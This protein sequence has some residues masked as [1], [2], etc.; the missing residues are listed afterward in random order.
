MKAVEI[1]SGSILELGA[2]FFSTP[3]LHWACFSDK[4]ELITYEHS[5]EYYNLFKEFNDTF[6]KVIK[7]DN[8][9]EAEIERSWD[10][11]LVDHD[12]NRRAKEIS[13][14]ANYVQYIVVHDSDKRLD[15]AYHLNEIYPLFKYHWKFREVKPHTSILSN[16]VDITGGI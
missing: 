8:W 13:R 2:G 14:L 7:V 5:V 4:R 12:G 11:A 9:D 10:V 3:Y 1:T 16:F 15:Y 6:H